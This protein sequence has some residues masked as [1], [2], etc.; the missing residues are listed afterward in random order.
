MT[1]P[2]TRD[3]RTRIKREVLWKTLTQQRA[4]A[5][6][7]ARRGEASIE[8]SQD[9]SPSASSRESRRPC[10]KNH[11][12]GHRSMFSLAFAKEWSWSSSRFRDA[13]ERLCLRRSDG[14]RPSPGAASLQSC[15]GPRFFLH[16]RASQHCCARGRAH[17]G[18]GKPQS[19][20]GPRFSFAFVCPNIAAPGDG[21]TPGLSMSSYLTLLSE[22]KPKR[23][24]RRLQSAARALVEGKRA[25]SRPQ[26]K[27]E[28]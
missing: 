19:C 2:R 1:T 24:P 18:R 21:R 15:N 17:S 6:A 10:G 11:V 5:L 3:K 26:A 8:C 20:N 28:I 25:W 9:S 23:L 16:L 22:M 4:V 27:A 13:Y 14:V 7:G 12:L